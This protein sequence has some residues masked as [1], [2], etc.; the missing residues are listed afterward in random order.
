LIDP[1][2]LLKAKSFVSSLVQR[3][4][5]GPGALIANSNRVS[6]LTKPPNVVKPV[7]KVITTPTSK[8]PKPLFT[9]KAKHPAQSSSLIVKQKVPLPQKHASPP[10]IERPDT[11]MSTVT[12]L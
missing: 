7:V 10:P 9:K 1:A 6:I 8:Q 4:P 11:M 12:D 3:E 2:E 5:L